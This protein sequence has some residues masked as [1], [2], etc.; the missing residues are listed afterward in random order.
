MTGTQQIGE[1]SKKGDVAKNPILGH[2]YDEPQRYWKLD[3]KYRTTDEIIEGRRPSGSYMRANES[4]GGAIPKSE[5]SSSIFAKSA[6]GVPPHPTINEIREIVGTWRRQEYP[7]T[8]QATHDLLDFWSSDNI[9]PKPYFCQ[10]EAVETA[11][12]LTEA[13]SVHDP[14]S[15]KQIT[16][17]LSK[18]AADWNDGIERIAIKMAT[19]T[20]KTLV[21]AML[22]LWKAANA[23]K[24]A[25]FLIIV[26]NLTVKSR[27][28]E[29]LPGSE[30]SFYER[31][32]PTGR[33]AAIKKIKVTIE[34]YHT[35][36]IRK[37]V[38]FEGF[39]KMPSGAEKALA[40]GGPNREDPPEWPETSTQMLARALKNFRGANEITVFNDEAHHCYRPA[41]TGLGTTAEENEF[42]EAATVWYSLLKYL[43]QDGRLGQ[44]Y[45]LS[46][47]P[48]YMMRPQGLGHNPFPWTVTDYPL[49]EAI[50]AGLTKIPRIPIADDTEAEEPKY[51]DT[52]NQMNKKRIGKTPDTLIVQLLRHMHEEYKKTLDRYAIQGKTPIMIV[53]A[54]D[55]KNAEDFYRHIAGSRTTTRSKGEEI[56][57]WTRG[58]Y[59]AFSNVDPK[60]QE[61]VEDPPTLLIHSGLDD[62][63]NETQAASTAAADQ[64]AFFP[65]PEI[66]GKKPSKAQQVEHIREI[67]QSVGKLGGKGEHIRCIVSVS[68][69][70]EGWDVRTVTQI[71]GYRAFTSQ[72]LCEQIAG[73]ALRRS[74]PLT[75]ER[76]KPTP[77]YADIFGV[78]FSFMRGA[79]D[80][81]LP[82][83]EEWVVRTLP[84]R[85]PLRIIFPCLESYQYEPGKGLTAMLEPYK[86]KQT[87]RPTWTKLAPAAGQSRK[88][89]FGDSTPARRSAIEYGLAKAAMER[90]IKDRG[91]NGQKKVL[92]RQR[93]LFA[94]LLIATREWLA[95]EKIGVSESN[96]WLLADEHGKNTA[97]EAIARACVS[98]VDGKPRVVPVFPEGEEP[99][100]DTGEVS[101]R[102]G[103]THRYP[104]DPKDT[105]RLSELNA[106]ACHIRNETRVAEILEN[107]SH[108]VAWARNYRLG[109]R[110][111]YLDPR[112]GRWRQY[113]P[114]F[115]AK[116]KMP[117][118]AL[119]NLV[120]EF[121]GDAES[122]DAK[123]K[124]KAVESC[125]LPAVN[126]SEELTQ[127]GFWHFCQIEN[128]SNTSNAI[129]DARQSGALW[130]QE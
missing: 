8:T 125:W 18:I 48:M 76:E 57:H 77:E 85:K 113:E 27:L 13:G 43:K 31:L 108:V 106:A 34:N 68:M 6:E 110:I 55:K 4:I 81:P 51:R 101:F 23:E 121:K 104:A 130:G 59:D 45:D 119:L 74:T 80:A 97:A 78:P 90:F 17:R 36:Q 62:P 14:E 73:R 75:S 66:D 69:L 46:A 65:A 99:L 29:L 64:A 118:G 49:I 58:A 114:D 30:T 37:N 22:M 60:A 98:E 12:W 56:E 115:I 70:T 91:G 35:F 102:T 38:V 21:M 127:D 96:L 19:G 9:E 116:V 123:I 39:S 126:G 122:E 84:D 41:Q 10:R 94:S 2:P 3:D 100:R 61:P 129:D 89:N 50:E 42:E 1:S 86:I 7:G 79:S 5:K 11:V 93:A 120:L 16:D 26:P 109:W 92:I 88:I 87:D 47:T 83:N 128:I 32:T 82:P 44:V 103:L 25:D 107:H 24:R 52:Y 54:N 72:L 71:F 33:K 105:T 63:T 28:Q 15:H 112:T 53:V 124:K 67:F 111:P 117:D 95:H 20:G 40:K